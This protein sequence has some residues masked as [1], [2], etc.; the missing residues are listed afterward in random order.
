[1]FLGGLARLGYRQAPV[2]PSIEPAD[3]LLIWNRA[4]R[5][6]DL[7]ARYERAGARVIVAENGYTGGDL[8]A[9]ALGHHN[10]AGEWPVG[11]ADRIAL[12][13][14]EI[15]PWRANGGAVVLLP[16]RGIGE[17]GVAMPRGWVEDVTRRLRAHTDRPIRMRPHPGK[18]REH[19]AAAL[20]GA[21]AAVTWGSGAGIKSI[22]F[23]VPV[24]HELPQWIGA[25]AA[26]FGIDAIE[27]P[28]T[29]DRLPMLRRLSWAQW[30]PAEIEDG[31]AFAALLGGQR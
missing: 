26:R 16:Q 20:A 7:A 13:A 8:Y 9:L 12:Q 10:G 17:R 22:L 24:F 25:P 30:T 14:L 6:G 2:P 23:G 5:W 3:L 15:R 4:G 28:F 31:Q 11:D 1:M 27:T 19:P 18:G 21:W 29:G